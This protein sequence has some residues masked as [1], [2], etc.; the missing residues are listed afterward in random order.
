MHKNIRLLQVAVLSAGL[1]LAGS[2]AAGDTRTTTT[3]AKDKAT[4]VAKEVKEDIKE[5][6]LN[7]KIR[8]TLLKTLKGADALRVN[9]TVHGTSATLSGEVEDRASEKLASEAAKSVEGVGAVHSKITLNPKAPHQDNFDSRVKDALLVTEVRLRLLQEVGTDAM[10]IS[11][12]ATDGTVS[13]RGEMPNST[14]RT[15]AVDNVK[16]LAGV[17]TVED[18]M[19]TTP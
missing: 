1:A 17:Q 5:T 11:I 4:K 3:K 2:A 8:M 15:R 12:T 10:G 19:S 16:Q 7:T 18:L 6:V 14:T 13:L 9:V